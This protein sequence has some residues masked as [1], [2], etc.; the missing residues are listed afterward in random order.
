MVPMIKVEQR[1]QPAVTAKDA[2][3]QNKVMAPA[4]KAQ[5]FY[6]ITQNILGFTAGTEPLMTTE[7]MMVNGMIIVI[8]ENEGSFAERLMGVTSAREAANA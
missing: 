6:M 1:A 8:S 7:V 4:I 3:G 5:S 2:Q